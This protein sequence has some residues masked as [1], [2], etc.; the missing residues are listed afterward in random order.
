MCG[1]T[2]TSCSNKVNFSNLIK[3]EDIFKI[4]E[5]IDKQP[6]KKIFRIITSKS[7]EI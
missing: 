1:I 3:A 7:L 4:V 2:F 5:K 6:N